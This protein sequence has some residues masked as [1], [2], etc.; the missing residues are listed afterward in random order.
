[1]KKCIFPLVLFLSITLFS[2]AQANYSGAYYVNGHFFHPTVSRDLDLTKTLTQVGPNRYEIN[3][4][5]FMTTTI[6][7]FSL[8]LTAQMI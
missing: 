3:V 5:D 4:G 1:M 8:K 2:N 7:Q 6:I